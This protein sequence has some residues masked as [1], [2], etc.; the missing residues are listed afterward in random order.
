MEAESEMEGRAE[1]EAEDEVVVAGEPASDGPG[2]L[3]IDD[4]D[5]FGGDDDE[6]DLEEGVD[7][8]EEEDLFMPVAVLH[9]GI[10]PQGVCEATPLCSD[11][12]PASAYLLVDKTVE[13]QPR[14]LREFTELGQ[15]PEDEEERQA[16]AVFINPR[17]AKRQCGRSQRVIKIPDTGILERTAPYLLAQGISRVVIE[18]TLYSLPGS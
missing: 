8:G 17:Q 9:T 1:M 10:E 3:A 6:D 11:D 7:D 18:G 2:V 14:P 16:L 12:L 4:A 13:L 15:L 5:D